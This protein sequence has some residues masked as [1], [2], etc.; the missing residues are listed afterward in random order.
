MKNTWD[1]PERLQLA[2]YI[3]L[4]AHGL[5]LPAYRAE[6]GANAWYVALPVI[7]G[8]HACA[9]AGFDLLQEEEIIPLP[10][11]T[12]MV[13]A[14]DPWHDVFLWAGRVFTGTPDQIVDAV[15]VYH[16]ELKA[17]APLSYLDLAIAAESPTSSDLAA[18][19]LEFLEKRLGG[20]RGPSCFRDLVLRPGVL[21]ELRRQLGKVGS[22]QIS[23]LL[24]DFVLRE[25]EPGLFEAD[26]APGTLAG[27]GGQ[28]AASEFSA[29]VARFGDILGLPL[30]TSGLNEN[31]TLQNL[32]QESAALPSLA[33]APRSQQRLR[34]PLPN[35]LVVVADRRAE[36]IAR[37]IE[38]P[39]EIAFDSKKDWS[40]KAYRVA[41]AMDEGDFPTGSDGLI[42]ITDRIPKQTR[43]EHFSLVVVLVG[44]ESLTEDRAASIAGTMHSMNPQI[45]LLIAPAPPADGPSMLLSRKGGAPTLLQE[46]SAVIDTTLARSP[47]WAGRPRRSADRRMAD[48]VVTVSV[49]SALQTRLRNRLASI[50]GSKQPYALSFIGGPGKFDVLHAMASELNAAGLLGHE[51]RSQHEQVAFELRE[52]GSKRFQNAFL[53]LQPLRQD[54]ERF[55]EAAVIE[56]IGRDAYQAERFETNQKVPDP[57]R[58]TLDDP[59]LAVAIH[60]GRKSGRVIVVSAEAPRI[61]SLR[62]AEENDAAVVRYT[63]IVSLRTLVDRDEPGILPAEIRLPG[64]HR[65]E[66]NRGLATRGVDVRDVLRLPEEQWKEMLGNNF[67]SE[68]GGQ[69]RQYLAAIDAR[70]TEMQI[71]LPI[72]AITNALHGGDALAQ[73][74]FDRFPELDEQYARS[75]KRTG[76]LIAAW[77]RP[78]KGASRWVIEDG[79]I[80]VRLNMLE[81]DEVPAQ[82]L[83]FVDGNNAVPFFLL[84]R[85]FSVWARALLPRAT[86]WASRFQVSKTF[87]AFPFPSTF[88]VRPA[89]GESPPHLRFGEQGPRQTELLQI[90]SEAAVGL[91]EDI[92]SGQGDH[93]VRRNPLVREFDSILLANIKLRP[94]ASD[95]DIL[96][97]L[98][99]R[100][101]RRA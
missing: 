70:E 37:Y 100:N 4:A 76:D 51:N 101:R 16:E 27:I 24:R 58:R 17:S 90:A 48:I 95:L 84:S 34:P 14:G 85:I 92:A 6:P 42:V 32:P 73:V 66:S 62:E 40:G 56:A 98:I 65:F 99:E 44:N 19:T 78:A 96:E 93:E 71:A 21:I 72:P 11:P 36:Q 15:A 1:A 30:R 94:D 69:A 68:L 43:L 38:P 46:C 22:T 12:T 53:E 97:S 81:D 80:P 74:L 9:V 10:T 50:R 25:Y 45:P 83:F 61:T 67:E 13:G 5:A 91:L 57:I 49:V 59:S 79:R 52:K 64:L 8:D 29:A 26:M 89:E 63:D 54:F 7:E 18:A 75:G 23:E 3:P 2:G 60:G 88:Q 82:R 47:F 39:P 55:A 86:S 20:V 77:S 33:T 31:E 87:D 28:Q 35:I 41:K